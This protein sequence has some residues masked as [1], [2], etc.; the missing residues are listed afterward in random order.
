MIMLYTVLTTEQSLGWGTQAQNSGREEED[1]LRPTQG[2][3]RSAASNQW[4]HKLLAAS[5]FVW[6]Q[7]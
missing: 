6:S 7:A 5:K 3:I 4:H 1:V 2:E